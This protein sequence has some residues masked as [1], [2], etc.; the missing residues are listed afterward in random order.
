MDAVAAVGDAANDLELLTMAGRSAA[1]GNAPAH[2]AAA[3]DI[4]V[5][6]SSASGVLHAFA[7][8][9]PDLADAFLDAEAA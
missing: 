2:V 6:P 3:A 8:F 9:F 1:M 7:W 5:P 4:V